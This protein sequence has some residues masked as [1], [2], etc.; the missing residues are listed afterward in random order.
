MSL[1]LYSYKKILYIEMNVVVADFEKSIRLHLPE[2]DRMSQ[3]EK[4]G[5]TDEVC[6]S[7]HG[8]F[9]N[10]DPIHGAVDAVKRLSLVYETYFLSAAMWNVPQ[11][12]SEKRLWVEKHFGDGFLKHLIL[13]HRKDLAFGHYLIDDRTSHGAG[14][15]IGKHIQFGS[16]E[17]P[18]WKSIVNY[19]ISFD[20]NIPK[21]WKPDFTI[22]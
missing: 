21:D 22:Y 5:Q 4:A 19:L 16:E 14:N 13:T 15:F 11:S 10:L 17:F 18:D 12:N 3:E 1:D 8:F 6:G 7:I 2:W 20:L 9:E